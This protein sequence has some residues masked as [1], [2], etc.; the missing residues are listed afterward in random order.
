MTAR[1]VVLASGNG[2]NFQE[3]IDASE[4]GTLDASIVGLVCNRGDA[5]ALERAAVKGVPATVLAPEAAELR[6]SYDA[7][8]ADVV[9]AMSPDLIVL[10]G[11]MRLLSMPFLGRFPQRV[12]NLH[13]ALPGQ[14]PGT[15]AIE[16][17]LDAASRGEIDHT[18]VMVHFVPDEGVDDGQAIATATVP[19]EPGDTIDTLSERVHAAERALLLRALRETISDVPWRAEP[20]SS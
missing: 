12:I 17:A 10:A 19:I 14:F 11:W 3:L 5:F 4:A 15:H 6:P 7:R 16:R 13:P 8:L 20:T 1:I 18:G 9:G 2:S